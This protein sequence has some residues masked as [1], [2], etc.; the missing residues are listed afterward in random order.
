MMS[1][2]L[3][4][5]GPTACGKS[6]LAL[7]IARR[8]PIEIVSV[9][10]AQVY[11]DMD[12][13]TAKPSKEIQSEIPHHLIDIQDPSEPYSAADFRHDAIATVK[14]IQ[15][16]DKIPLL[17]GGTM[18]YLKAL[19]D[20]MAS[21]PPAN[22]EIRARIADLAAQKGWAF[23]HEKL[24]GV[25]PEAA[26]RISPN[27]P[28]RLQRALEVYEITGKSL[29]AHHR[30]EAPPS[31]FDLLE[32]AIMPPDR[33]LLHQRIEARFDVMLESGFLREVQ[34]LYDRNDLDEN[35]PSIKA[36][37]YRQAWSH[38]QGNIDYSTMREMAIVATRQLAKRQYTW[39][40]SWKDL[41]LIESADINK[42]LKILSGASILGVS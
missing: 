26:L 17:V 36:V 1:G 11:R 7:E 9:D 38:L 34:N 29:T 30:E 41:H 19:K 5:T 21:L 24:Q 20:G 31:P 32:I 37:G 3:V 16:R 23:I 39:L 33:A 2:A 15:A 35:L 4:I 22:E 10:S 14:D 8:F 25:D 27:D 28:Q 12:I 6:D 42:A 18:L 40:R 13:G